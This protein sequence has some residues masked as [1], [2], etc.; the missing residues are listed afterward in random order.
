ML[1]SLF[2]YIIIIFIIFLNRINYLH[3][4]K[5][6][7]EHL[8]TSSSLKI[9]VSPFHIIFYISNAFLFEA[10][11]FVTFCYKG[12]FCNKHL[13]HAISVAISLTHKSERELRFY[14]KVF[15]RMTFFLYLSI[16]VAN[17]F[18]H[19]LMSFFSKTFMAC[20]RLSDW[21]HL[22]VFCNWLIAFFFFFLFVA[23]HFLIT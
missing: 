16:I 12:V 5:A 1:L 18:I 11:A 3:N 22:Q 2:F 10:G 8:Q 21:V 23:N 20:N 6:T 4:E 15:H 7:F 13:Y 9:L 17:D 14:K 19:G